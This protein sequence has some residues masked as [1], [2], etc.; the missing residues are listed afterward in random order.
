MVEVCLNS[1]NTKG[2]QSLCENCKWCAAEPETGGDWFRPSD[3]RVRFPRREAAEYQ[4]RRAKIAIKL[5]SKQGKDKA[6][7]RIGRKAA[8]AEK[9]T[10]K[11]IIKSTVN[12][13]RSNNDGDHISGG[14]IVLD[15]KMQSSRTHPVIRLE[16][17][18]KVRAQAKA[19]GYPM[20]ALV[21]R[22][23][24]NQG[25][26]VMDEADFAVLVKERQ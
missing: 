22:N 8:R 6:R 2:T 7:V 14:S 13:G 19:A 20:G 11:S 1:P 25:F 4:A 16:E 24:L 18:T 10:E 9:T 26:V 21:L 12:S 15:T 3:K 17:L 5:A 23:R